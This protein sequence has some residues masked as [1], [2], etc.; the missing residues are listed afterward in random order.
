MD[1][2]KRI[3]IIL[4]L[5]LLSALGPFSIDLYLPGFPEIA[6]DLNTT[7]SRVALSL[8]SYFVGVSIGQLIYGPLL[9]RFG[10]R[11]PLLVGLF[12][13]LFASIYIVY[14]VSIDSLIIA[15]FV[16]AIGGCAGMV[17]ARA[18]VRDLFPVSEIA[19][20]FSLLMLV[21]AVSPILAP[22]IGGF[23]TAHWGWH[24]I[25]IILSV[26]VLINILLVYFWL[27]TGAAPD[28]TLSLKPRPI[29]N[30][31]W[32][33]FK[34]PQFLTY[35]LTGSFAASG[36]YAYIA[37]SPH[38][39]ME[40]YGVTEKQ[41]GWIF[42]II[43]LGLVTASQFN[44]LLLRK[45]TSEYI[46][47]ITLICQVFFGTALLLGALFNIIEMYSMIVLVFLFLSTQGFAFPNT[48]ALSLAPFE[49]SAGTASALM[50]ALQLGIGALITG[51]VS[52]LSNET[53][54]PMIAIMF[55]CATV[56][57]ALLYLGSRKIKKL[58]IAVG[59]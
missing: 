2:K 9:D 37:G 34:N 44:T 33:V 43:A 5:G 16:Q 10:R 48:S 7:T 58:K 25:F 11:I 29:I 31:F 24:S 45:Y 54:I 52:L 36:L 42:A 38:V 47:K 8:S 4:I 21:I 51:L 28:K 50:G 39:F 15:R 22:T 30:N 49:R 57:L 6:R 12:T 1:K 56:S 26:L 46:V 19:K 23:A 17:A 55:M 14:V 32:Q 18:L 41:Y 53:P 13:Y 40:L 20:I 3:L 35:T 27:P 59:S